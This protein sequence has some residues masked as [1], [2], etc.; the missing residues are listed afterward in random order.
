MGDAVTGHTHTHAL[1]HIQLCLYEA[2]NNLFLPMVSQELVATS[3]GQCEQLT[4]YEE[5]IW[6]LTPSAQIV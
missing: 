5:A 4:M 1:G 6:R 2:A 3:L